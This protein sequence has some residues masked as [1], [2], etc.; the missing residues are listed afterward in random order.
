M[1]DNQIIT[2]NIV[3]PYDQC[4]RQ[5]FSM[6]KPYFID[7]YQREYK[8]EKEKVET[9]LKDIEV[10]FESNH[11]TKTEPKEI[12]DDVIQNFEPYFLN[13][14]LTHT[15]PAEIS[16]IDGQ[17]RLTTFLLIFIK[18]L[19]ILKIVGAD[20]RYT[21]KTV[22]SQTLEKLI[23]ESD[24][25]GEAKRFKICNKNRDEAFRS[26]IED[27]YF[28]PVGETQQKIRDNF[29]NI[30]D[31]YDAFFKNNEQ[32]DTY[33][34]CKL[35]Y[36]ITYLLDRVAIVEI[37][38]EKQ[39]NVALIFE[40]VNDRGLRLKPYEIL[41]GKLIGN[42]PV[43]I[44][45]EANDIWTK[46]QN[47]YFNAKI[48]NS[49]VK[50]LDLDIFFQ[51]YF[52]AKFADSEN[53]YEKFEKDYHY[54]IYNNP[55]IKEYFGNFSNPQLL[56]DYLKNDIKYFAETY[57]QLRTSY[58]NEYL[59]YNKLLDQNQQYL[60]ILSGLILNDP[61][62]DTKISIIAKKFDQFHT[63]IRLLNVYESNAFQ[64]LIYPIN[65]QIRGKSIEEINS[66]FNSSLLNFLQE[67]DI[68]RKDEVK[69]ITDLFSY[70]RFKGANNQLT[71]FSKYILMRIDRYLALH[72]DK[73]SYVGGDLKLLED[74][75]NKS[76]R[77]RFAL[78]LEHIYANNDKNR[79]L[80][81]INPLY[82]LYDENAFTSE[83]NKL[84]MVLL[85]TDKQNLSSGD[86]IYRD[87]IKTYKQ[88][89]IIWNELLVGDLAEN[90][91]R[92]LPIELSTS[93]ILPN[94][95]GTFPR[96]QVESRQKII[97]NAI[98]LLW[99]FE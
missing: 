25:F 84:G 33:D 27:S 65:R 14:Y 19:K 60:L 61:F 87:K 70:E 88:S 16:I 44:K 76:T 28:N 4:L 17:Q 58:D 93:P 8:W 62:R 83:R 57:L 78:Q 50:T 24:D 72:L 81:M 95:D 23:F 11:R 66:I 38:I 15:T 71:N 74:R 36:Y 55:K 96:D 51:A 98:K 59:I 49:D 54:E 29:K 41:K 77:V 2:R 1:A 85:L 21:N 68:I 94:Q 86:D 97:F 5:V 12:Q 26:L 6:V 3:T 73:P 34:L 64:S 63:L 31:Y 30:S 69:S 90:H 52:R 79:E 47:S 89:D 99:C 9:L 18:I 10:Q 43:N 53:D 20:G 82:K 37:H 42:L 80:F 75:F 22:N 35:T 40:V 56:Y 7:I 13:T 48:I 67:K 91:K 39:K 46:L 45:E 92:N 32:P